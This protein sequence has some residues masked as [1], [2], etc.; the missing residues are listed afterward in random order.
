MGA[1]NDYGHAWLTDP[2]EAYKR[3]WED[4]AWEDGHGGYSGTIATSRGFF[5][6]RGITAPMTVWE[7]TQ[8]VEDHDLLDSMDKWDAWGAIPVFGRDR[9]KARERKLTLPVPEGMIAQE[10]AYTRNVAPAVVAQLD[11]KPIEW[12]EAKPIGGAR[13]KVTA[14]TVKGE[15]TTRY[16]YTD[17]N[18]DPGADFKLSHQTYYGPFDSQAA[19]YAA[20]KEEAKKRADNTFYNTHP[21]AYNIVAITTKDNA[22]LATVTVEPTA[23]KVEAN[24]SYFPQ[25]PAK[26]EG[27]YF[28]GWAAS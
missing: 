6:V 10:Y 1:H 15:R 3:L 19:A 25:R 18:R 5:K 23:T 2:D 13:A 9:S 4:A 26:L 17:S 28:F 27:W 20:A 22:P 14:A 24:V 21:H 11:G 12:I 8:Y 7:A 16:Y